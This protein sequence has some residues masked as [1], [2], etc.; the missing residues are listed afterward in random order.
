MLAILFNQ[1]LQVMKL[2][3]LRG[4]S[5]KGKKGAFCLHEGL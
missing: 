3:W 1:I 5:D 2:G 4:G